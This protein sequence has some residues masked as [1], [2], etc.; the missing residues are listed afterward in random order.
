[1][2]LHFIQKTLQIVAQNDILYIKCGKILPTAL[3]TTEN[4]SK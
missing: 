2:E 4:Q 3:C 1:M